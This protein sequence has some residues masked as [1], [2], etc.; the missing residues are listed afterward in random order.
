VGGSELHSIAE[1]ATSLF[2]GD[3]MVGKSLWFRAAMVDNPCA[4]LTS[5]EVGAA[6]A[7]INGA[8][9]VD[10]SC[11]VLPPTEVDVAQADLH[12]SS[13]EGAEVCSA[14]VGRVAGTGPMKGAVPAGGE[15]A[16]PPNEV[17]V[18]AGRG[19]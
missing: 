10:S 14:M 4:V 8:A 6:Q 9:M 5:T 17:R 7:G 13:E 2:S 16:C 11:T 18:V 19:E 15:A 12:P 1:D 3:A